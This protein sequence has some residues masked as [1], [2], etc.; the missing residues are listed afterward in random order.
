MLIAINWQ[1]VGNCDPALPDGDRGFGGIRIG[2]IGGTTMLRGLPIPGELIPFGWPNNID[3]VLMFS[4][5]Q[6]KLVCP[7]RHPLE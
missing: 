2:R 4:Q 6:R 7:T 3:M 1:S 5:L